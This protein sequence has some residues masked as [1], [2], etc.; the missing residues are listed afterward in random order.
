MHIK[1]SGPGVPTKAG[2]HRLPDVKAAQGAGTDERPRVTAGSWLPFRFPSMTQLACLAVFGLLRSAGVSAAASKG[3]DSL[4]SGTQPMG[5][6]NFVGD[7]LD[8]GGR[9]VLVGADADYTHG[10]STSCPIFVQAISGARMWAPTV[11]A[12]GAK[13]EKGVHRVNECGTWEQNHDFLNTLAVQKDFK[14]I[15]EDDP[16]GVNLQAFTCGDGDVAV[17][18]VDL[19]FA[20]GT[21]TGA[22]HSSE[23]RLPWSS[24]VL[25]SRKPLAPLPGQIFQLAQQCA[26]TLF[27]MGDQIWALL[28]GDVA[29]PERAAAYWTGQNYSFCRLDLGHGIFATAIV[30]PVNGSQDFTD[31]LLRNCRNP[32]SA[33]APSAPRQS[34]VDWAPVA[35]AMGLVVGGVAC[36]RGRAS[37]DRKSPPRPQA[38]AQRSAPAGRGRPRK[39]QPAGGRDHRATVAEL[40]EPQRLPAGSA[41][42]V[43]EEARSLIPDTTLRDL[44][45]LASRWRG[46]ARESLH[47]NPAIASAMLCELISAWPPDAAPQVLLGAIRALGVGFDEVVA[48]LETRLAA[49]PMNEELAT[50]FKA[51]SHFE[52]LIRSLAAGD[53]KHATPQGESRDGDALV[54]PQQSDPAARDLSISDPAS[55]PPTRARELHEVVALTKELVKRGRA[56]S[57]GN[58]D[59]YPG[60]DIPHYHIDQK[61]GFVTYKRKPTDHAYLYRHGSYQSAKM[62]GVRAHVHD[63]KG[64]VGRFL[65]FIDGRVTADQILQDT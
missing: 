63:H 25:A 53:G 42:A 58:G 35:V 43:R 7:W 46:E 37:G 20:L 30:P 8:A 14:L 29:D 1:G 62:D 11:Y 10:S 4:V 51:L 26:P 23:F 38:P 17:G 3:S 49:D 64:A 52:P 54:Q 33:S 24:Q 56:I 31:R 9:T 36:L 45:M 16:Q 32:V 59:F 22:P 50:E 65:D 27:L 21:R 55:Q 13:D 48:A 6:Q 41:R 19:H 47:R 34:A 44:R 57:Q 40:S 2:T 28:D 60:L 61:K 15:D 39:A 5:M 12:Q 18:Q